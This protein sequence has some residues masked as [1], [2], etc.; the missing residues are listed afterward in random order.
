MRPVFYGDTEHVRVTRRFLNDPESM[1]AELG[2][3]GPSAG[4]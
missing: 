1:L 2:F 3:S 4:D